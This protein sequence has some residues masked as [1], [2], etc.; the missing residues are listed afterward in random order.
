V[1]IN[2]CPR[3]KSGA[4][5]IPDS[6]TLLLKIKRQLPYLNPALKRIA[7]YVSENPAKI[8]LLKI[9]EL[10][11]KCEVSE[12]TVT[13]FVRELNIATFQEFKIILADMVFSDPKTERIEDKVVYDDVAKGDSVESL[14]EKIAFRNLETLE[15]TKKIINSVVIEK[16]VKA[17]DSSAIITIYCVGTSTIAA[18]SARMR[19]YRIGK[20]CIV[21]NDPANQAVS[22]SLLRKN[23]VAIGISNSG[24][25]APT[26]NALR[27]AQKSGAKTICITSSNTSPITRFADIKLYTVARQSSFFQESLASRVAQVF[28]IDILYA[29]YALKHYNKSIKM[30]EASAAALV[31][32]LHKNHY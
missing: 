4:A 32:V 12:A 21:Y 31:K 14:I 3:I 11:S 19:F 5:M 9:K 30:V 6:G 26:V 1:G 27:M 8:K 15:E 16:A 25:S 7:I 22:S 2:P 13:R 24:Q 18:E 28:I 23:S 10:T 29:S 20:E 17:I